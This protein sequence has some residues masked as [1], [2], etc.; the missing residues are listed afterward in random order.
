MPK[1]VTHE[2]VVQIL[3]S[4]NPDV[5]LLEKYKDSRTKIL[6]R[7][8]QCN[9]EWYAWVSALEQGHGCPKC[10]TLR[11]AKKITYTQEE[12]E[13]IVAIKSPNT[14]IIG[15]YVKTKA[16]IECECK[17]CGNIWTTMAG[18]L[19]AGRGCPVCGL[20]AR[21]DS[22]RLNNDIFL[23]RLKEN[24]LPYT[25]LE[26][27][28]GNHTKILMRCNNCGESWMATPHNLQSG[29]GCPHCRASKGEEKIR[30]FLKEH[31][32]EYQEQ[33]TFEGCKTT[34]LLP[35]DFY[36]PKLNMCIEFDGLQHFKPVSFSSDKT[37]VEESFKQLQKRDGIKN[38]YCEENG[39][40]LLRIPYYDI[41][42]I[43]NILSE[44]VLMIND[45]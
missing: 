25:P 2:E 32:I 36:L 35:F 14:K 6:T 18:N 39:I 22:K 27:Y 42:D 13:Q 10:A 12:F 41:D 37:N 38:K 20:K 29:F 8:K 15:K 5:E 40:K 34:R 11:N 19:Q 45:F 7:C 24:E 1:I 23:Q 44:K 43:E 17:V 3:A 33:C 31:D 26:E 30:K 4:A 21:N 28:K 16:P 9:H